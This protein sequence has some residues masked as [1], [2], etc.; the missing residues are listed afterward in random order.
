[1]RLPHMEDSP[2]RLISL[3]TS[4]FTHFRIPNAKCQMPNIN[5]TTHSLQ[6]LSL[7][8]FRPILEIQAEFC[9][10]PPF[11]RRSA[12]ASSTTNS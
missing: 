5:P 10:A 11:K 8:I 7:A 2:H 12:L 4:Y 3:S 1:M 6:F 9:L